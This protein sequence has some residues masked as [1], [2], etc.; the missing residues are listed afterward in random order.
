MNDASVQP[1]GL[2][3]SMPT[4][5]S[6]GSSKPTEKNQDQHDNEYEAEPAATVLAGPV[7]ETAS[8]PAKAS[9]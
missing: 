9:E 2:S 3:E 4:C 6:P 1:I 7:E 8:E 5:S